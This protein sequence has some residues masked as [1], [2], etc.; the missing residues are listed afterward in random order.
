[1]LGGEFASR[2]EMEEDLEDP[3]GKSR[4]RSRSNIGKPRRVE[5]GWMERGGGGCP[6]TSKAG[7]AGGGKASQGQGQRKPAGVLKRLR[8]V[9]RAASQDEEED[10][11]PPRRWRAT[12]DISSPVGRRSSGSRTPVASGRVPMRSMPRDSHSS[13]AIQSE[14]GGFDEEMEEEFE[15]EDME[16]EED[17][18]GYEEEDDGSPK[19]PMRIKLDRYGKPVGSHEPLLNAALQKFARA[20]DPT[21]TPGWKGQQRAAKASLIER[22]RTEFEFYGD[23]TELSEKWFNM[24]MSRCVTRVKFAINKLIRL[25]HSKPPDIATEHWDKLVEMR[26]DPAV[27]EKSQMMSSI[28]L[29]RPSKHGHAWSQSIAAV[30]ALVSSFTTLSV[31]SYIVFLV[32]PFCVLFY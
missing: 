30:S 29:G 14:E 28:S 15:E 25:G 7:V 9:D 32:T 10:A 24:R 23:S 22:V 20:L 17:M 1:M 6:P 2:S 26:D 31:S 13:Q 16:D 4:L 21:A 19:E 3:R 5:T 12:S 18:E 8:G 11:T 27:Q